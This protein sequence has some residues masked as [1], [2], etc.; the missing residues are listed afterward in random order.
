MSTNYKT[1]TREEYEAI[2]DKDKRITLANEVILFLDDKAFTIEGGSYLNIS[3]K[4]DKKSLSVHE[5]FENKKKIDYCVVCVKGALFLNHFKLDGD[6]SSDGREITNSEDMI[7]LFGADQWHLIEIAFEEGI[8][9]S[10]TINEF[11]NNINIKNTNE[12]INKAI[13]F[14]KKYKTNV[15]RFRGIMSN[16]IKND[17]VF[18]P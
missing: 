1:P 17:G 10:S 9:I 3:Y 12:I 6:H 13:K 16:I 5:I 14:G 2:S 11:N 4:E 7:Q 18:K 8:G 15:G